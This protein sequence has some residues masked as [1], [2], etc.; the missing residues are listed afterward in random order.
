MRATA[1]LFESKIAQDLVVDNTAMNISMLIA[2]PVE[3]VIKEGA[4]DFFNNLL[5]SEYSLLVDFTL[6]HLCLA[7]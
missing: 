5:R 2:H 6:N 4:W 7:L 3:K 1:S